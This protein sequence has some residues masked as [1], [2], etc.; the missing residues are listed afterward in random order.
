MIVVYIY[1]WFNWFVYYTLYCFV[2]ILFIRTLYLE[3]PRDRKK[4]KYKIE[5]NLDT[6]LYI[7]FI[8]YI[9]FIIS[10]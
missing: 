3:I 9:Y 7:F 1:D 4:I 5:N 10:N 8:Y 6:S 2:Y